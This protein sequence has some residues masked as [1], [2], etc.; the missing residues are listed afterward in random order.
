MAATMDVHAAFDRQ[1]I[2]FEG[3][4][5]REAAVDVAARLAQRVDGVPVKPAPASPEPIVR[6]G[7]EAT[8]EKPPA[9]VEESPVNPYAGLSPIETLG[10]YFKNIGAIAANVDIS[11]ECEEINMACVRLAAV[12]QQL[13]E[14][15]VKYEEK[16]HKPCP[17]PDLLWGPATFEVLEDRKTMPPEVLNA[18]AELKLNTSS[19]HDDFFHLPDNPEEVLAE[20]K[21]I[22]EAMREEIAVV[23][24]AEPPPV[25]GAA[26]GVKPS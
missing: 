21:D 17:G 7:P 4:G 24:K 6:A 9:P 1:K 23:A 12:T 26:G 2:S 13:P 3:V 16:Y 5:K 11:G 22:M 15:A 8:P 19:Q 18:V 10:A 20:A 25:G 14:Y